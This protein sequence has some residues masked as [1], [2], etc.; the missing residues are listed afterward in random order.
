MS[1]QTAADV[2]EALQGDQWTARVIRDNIWRPPNREDDWCAFCMVGR[3]GSGKSHTT[4]SVLEKADPTY[5]ASRV[6][7]DPVEMMAFIA[8]LSPSERSGKAIHLDEAGVGMGIRSWYDK[9]QIKVNKAAQTMR[10]DNMI[11][12]TTLPSF[13]LMDGQ[14]RTRHH[15][16]CEMRDL[17][18]G[19]HAVWSWKNIIVNREE[20]GDTIKRKQFPR[21]W[22]DGRVVK[23]ERLKIRPPSDQWIE[24]YE[25]RKRAFKQAYYEEVIEEVEDEEEMGPKEVAAEI[26]ADGRLDEFVSTHSGNKTP[27]VDDD[28]IHFEYPHLTN[29]EAKQVKKALDREMEDG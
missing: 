15:G 7:F 17:E 1:I 22:V 16:F 28:L 26:L 29:K 25:A 18:R 4:A 21:Y 5:D 14:L 3:E 6:F 24:N 20:D 8:D 9:D 10:D 2:P 19:E 13:S 27:Y 23:V 11:L 12:A